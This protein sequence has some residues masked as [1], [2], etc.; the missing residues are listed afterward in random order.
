M[1]NGQNVRQH[2]LGQAFTVGIRQPPVG[3]RT[4][5]ELK[6]QIYGFFVQP[7]HFISY[8]VMPR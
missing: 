6:D 8:R 5:N 2:L 1:R 3:Q 4:P 7:Y